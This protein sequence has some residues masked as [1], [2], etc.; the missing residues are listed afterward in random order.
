[1]IFNVCKFSKKLRSY[2][3]KGRNVLFE[4]AH[5]AE[6]VDEGMVLLQANLDDMNPEWTSY[7][8]D[9]LFAAGAND[10]FWIPIVMKRGRPGVM[11]NVLAS[12]ERVEPLE[13]I[14][15]RETTTLGIRRIA[16]EV[17]RLGRRMVQVQTKWGPAAVKIGVA[18]GEEV[19]YA[20]EYRECAAIAEREGVPLKAVYDEV[21][22]A[23]LAH[24][25]A[26][27]GG[28]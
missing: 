27:G 12:R 19:Q 4:G 9:A 24:G 26:E 11:L 22:R 14:V 16:A 20:P 3:K 13:R 17:H 6:H 7:V 10:V 1:M 21:R 18:N 23:Y 8:S 5:G 25:G 2:V 15:F 28:R